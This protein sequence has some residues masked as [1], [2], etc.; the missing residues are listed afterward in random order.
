MTIREGRP[1]YPNVHPH[2]GRCR[3]VHSE[4]QRYWISL[5]NLQRTWE[6]DEAALGFLPPR[7]RDFESSRDWPRR[8]ALT[9]LLNNLELI[10]ESYRRLEAGEKLDYDLL[11]NGLELLTLHLHPWQGLAD[12]RTAARARTELGGR[13]ETLRVTTDRTD[14]NAGTR[15]IRATVERGLYY[16]A[17]YVDDRL[18]DPTYPDVSPGRPHVTLAADGSGDL[19]L[20]EPDD[21]SSDA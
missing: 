2:A 19:E 15:Y 4:Q 1:P 21:E 8:K 16:F 5:L 3:A 9:F 6:C 13:I 10:R 20:V 12:V 18:A 7:Y 17:Q 11:N 14:L